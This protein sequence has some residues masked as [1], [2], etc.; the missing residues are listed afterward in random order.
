MRACVRARAYLLYLPP[1]QSVNQSINQSKS[2]KRWLLQ[3]PGMNS[4][5]HRNLYCRCRCSLIE[6]PPPT[7]IYTSTHSLLYFAPLPFLPFLLHFTSL[8]FTFPKAFSV[9]FFPIP[10]ST[11]P[12]ISYLLS[13][14]SN[15]LP[16]PLQLQLQHQV[17]P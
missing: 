1:S 17:S 12:A 13:S 11:N 7:T 2:S 4:E 3:Q 8:H 6:Q 9:R 5:F 10:Q 15:Q 16:L 14:I